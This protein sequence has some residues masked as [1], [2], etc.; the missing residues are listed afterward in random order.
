[1][2]II[3]DTH[4]FLW[5]LC[6]DTK[7]SYK[8]KESIE[9]ENNDIFISMASFWEISIKLSINKLDLD[10]KYEKLF[11]EAKKLNIKILNI[12]KEHLTYLRNLA[13]FHKDP[14]DRLIIS[15]A[16]IENMTLISDDDIFKDYNL[17]LLI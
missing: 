6:N 12:K 13:F 2:K 3:I 10:I 9:D 5:F 4:I 1:M 14:F 11:E 17:N 16:K 8:A 7:L 15:Q